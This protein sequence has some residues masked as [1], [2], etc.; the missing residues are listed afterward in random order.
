MMILRQWKYFTTIFLY[1]FFWKYFTAIFLDWDNC[2]FWDDTDISGYSQTA[3]QSVSQSVSQSDGEWI[4]DPLNKA[5]LLNKTFADK[6]TIDVPEFNEYSSL[7]PSG[8]HQEACAPMTVK[9]GFNTLKALRAESATGPDVLPTRVLKEC[10][11][12]LAAPFVSLA[13]YILRC[14]IW[15]AMWLAHWIIPL[16]KKKAKSNPT[17]YR[18][19]HLT[20][21]LSRSHGALATNNVPTLL[22][23]YHR[24]WWEPIRL[25]CRPRSPWCI[26]IARVHMARGVRRE[27]KIRH[28][29]LWCQWRIRQGGP[30]TADQQ[31]RG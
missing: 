26:G 2:S 3:S 29:L 6:C 4:T 21:Q 13:Q 20:A 5:D 28:L 1:F 22:C 31:I 23:G 15:P 18:G 30:R 17:N 9:D 16:Y 19:V 25:Q 10:A 24:F 27:M 7:T 12:E 14:G 11:E 8:I